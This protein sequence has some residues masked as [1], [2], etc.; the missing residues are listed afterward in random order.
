M[1]ENGAARG[2]RN[3]AVMTE[4]PGRAPARAMLR[5]A[6]F[7]ADDLA[8]PIIGVGHAWIETM[9]CNFNHR[10]LADQAKAGI[11][12]AGGTPMEFNTIAVSDGVS[13]GTEGM[14]ASL[15]SREV[16]AD[17][18]EVVTRGHSFDGLVL[19]VGCDKTIPAAAMALCRLD[20]P[21]LILYS[22][23]I[24]AGRHGGR[25]ITIQDVFEAV[26][27]HAAG[28][29]DDAELR[30]VEEAACPG[31]GACAGQ[32]TANTMS[33][34]MEFLGLSPAGANDIPAIDERKQAAAFEAGRLAMRLVGE[35]VRPRTLATRGAFENAIAC[36]T[37]SGGSTNAVLH[38]LAIAAEAG[39]PLELADFDRISAR[40]PILADLKPGGRFVAADVHAA[41][42]LAVLGRR[43]QELGLLDEDCLTVD[44]RTI[45][46]VASSAQETPGQ[47]VIRA[48][49][50]PLKD[51]G[52][53]A[54][55]HGALA[56]DGC[57]VKLA[58]HDRR[59]HRGPA[60]VFENEESCFAA[61]QARTIG[62]GDVVVI[63]NEGPVGGPGM[64]E[65][66]AVT[67]AI[68][69]AGL[70]DSVALITDGR[71]SGATHGF[72]VA[73]VTPEAALGGPIAA[74]RDGDVITV[75]VDRRRIEIDVSAA[76]LEARVLAW[77][78]P[79]ARY[80]YGA[81]AKY[82][83][84]VGSASHGALT[85]P[86]PPAGDAAPVARSGRT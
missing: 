61:V 7:T 53:I 77:T 67:G 79:P 1:S 62:D 42:G 13:M 34:A 10:Q 4:G 58:G 3:S 51:R 68:V 38:L 83:A 49:A 23:T 85:S 29:I 17:S 54:V 75:D 31:A 76:E 2:K 8:K 81:L 32:F 11:R 50:S 37:A 56:P 69:G 21:G 45:G 46:E 64:R 74:V 66:L 40:T 47:E 33:T 9:P 36:V 65:M 57:V 84:M 82:A 55:L 18:I 52:G 14:R 26:G 41:G 20:L 30:A 48:A 78:P 16:I 19:I 35:G 70:S 71:F 5:A 12:A 39:V 59:L 24:A 27:A 28:T 15:V 80:Q 6:G 22:G 86:V 25:D 72:M 43:L 73:H 63:R 60:R 44:A